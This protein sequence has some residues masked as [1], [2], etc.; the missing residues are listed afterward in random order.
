MGIPWLIDGA[1]STNNDQ[2][3]KEAPKLPVALE[4]AITQFD[5]VGN[6]GA[7]YSYGI[8]VSEGSEIGQSLEKYTHY[9]RPDIYDSSITLIST[10]AC[11]DS[12]TSS[13]CSSQRGQ[14]YNI[15]FSNL[16]NNTS[17]DST[18][19]YEFI[20]SNRRNLYNTSP[21]RGD[22]KYGWATLHDNQALRW[23]LTN[24]RIRVISG[25]DPFVGTIGLSISHLTSTSSNTS[26]TSVPSFLETLRDSVG[27]PSLSW[28]YC[29]SPTTTE[30]EYACLGR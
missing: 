25:L 5:R 4:P 14:T 9:L 6:D 13:N 3:P 29:E 20:N 16:S 18:W 11:F 24:Q 23:H 2:K 21:E 1:F 30:G 12:V 19:T 15:S 22:I 27:L 26:S 7:W 8:V 28:S 10:E 17:D